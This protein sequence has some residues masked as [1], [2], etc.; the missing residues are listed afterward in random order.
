MKQEAV[1]G[2]GV[3]GNFAHH[4]EQAG[5]LEDFKDVKTIEPNA[6]KGIFPFYLPKSKTFLGTYP[7][8]TERL[9]LP[10][11]EANA[12]VEPEIAILFDI[13]YDDTMQVN[14][15]NAIKFTVFNDCTIRKEGAK[16]ISEKKSWGATSKGIGKEWIAID[17]FEVGGVMDDYHLCSFVKRDGILHPYGINAPLSGYSY[18]YSKLTNWLVNTMNTQEDFGPLEDIALHIKENEYPS[19]ALIT[20]GATAYAE[21]GEKNYL[22]KGDEIFVVS[23]NAKTQNGDLVAGDE[24]VILHQEVF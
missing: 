22:Q 15:L 3:A 9:E 4:L 1:I 11:Y 17:K 10:S 18:F 2:L 23:Y 20:I 14:T 12:Q 19:Q 24:K 6:P 5:E 7:I 16:K 13:I 8:C 21:F